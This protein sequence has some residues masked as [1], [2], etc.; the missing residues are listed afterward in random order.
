MNSPD[1]SP[2]RSAKA[3]TEPAL[4]TTIVIESADPVSSLPAAHDIFS[5]LPLDILMLVFRELVAVGSVRLGM[6]VNPTSASR[7]AL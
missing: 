2:K 4:M 3:F 7:G 6:R 5:S 1:E